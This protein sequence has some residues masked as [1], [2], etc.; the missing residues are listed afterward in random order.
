MFFDEEEGREIKKRG[1]GEVPWM[2]G[3]SSRFGSPTLG[4]PD[5]L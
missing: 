1:K 3:G 2:R 5:V 4:P